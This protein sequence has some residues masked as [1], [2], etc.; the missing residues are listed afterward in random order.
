MW[1]VGGWVRES[2]RRLKKDNFL[3][4]RAIQRWDEEEAGQPSLEGSRH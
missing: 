2:I 3:K 1:G 4:T